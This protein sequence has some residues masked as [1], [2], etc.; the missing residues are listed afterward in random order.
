MK[1]ESKTDFAT[2]RSERGFWNVFGDVDLKT[3]NMGI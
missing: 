1:E 3:E 2:K